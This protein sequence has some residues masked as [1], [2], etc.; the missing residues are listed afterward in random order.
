MF[1]LTACVN[2]P[3]MLL[4]GSP[5]T[6]E[7]GEHIKMACIIFSLFGCIDFPSRDLLHTLWG[8]NLFHIL[9]H[10]SHI[11]IHVLRLIVL[12]ML[13]GVSWFRGHKSLLDIMTWM[14][15]SGLKSKKGEL[16]RA[17]LINWASPWAPDSGKRH[18]PPSQIL[19][20]W[21]VE[22]VTA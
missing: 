16:L 3:R 1:G 7:T 5:S 2:L 17:R 6:P 20:I 13:K 22:L 11:M 18:L 14:N 4:T 21:L 19:G 15:S 10:S 8:F 12:M 9:Q